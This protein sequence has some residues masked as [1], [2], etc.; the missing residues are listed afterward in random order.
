MD[1]GSAT[2]ADIEDFGGPDCQCG[3]CK[4]ARRRGVTKRYNHGPWLPAWRLKAEGYDG[5]RVSI[6]G[7]PDYRGVEEQLAGQEALAR[8]AVG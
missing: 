6:P 7:D 5:N 4:S 2:I 1:Q 3:E 8:E